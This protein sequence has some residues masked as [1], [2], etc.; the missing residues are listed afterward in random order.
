MNQPT[1][2]QVHRFIDQS[3]PWTPENNKNW[4]FKTHRSVVF[5]FTQKN[6]KIYE[7]DKK[8]LHFLPTHGFWESLWQMWATPG[9]KAARTCC[10]H[11]LG[12]WSRTCPWQFP[13]WDGKRPHQADGRT[14]VLSNAISML[15][16]DWLN[17]NKSHL[18]THWYYILRY[19]IYIYTCNW[20]VIR[21]HHFPTS[22]WTGERAQL[23][24]PGSVTMP[25]APLLVKH[26]NNMKITI[27]LHNR[28]HIKSFLSLVSGGWLNHHIFN[29]IVG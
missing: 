26:E 19:S 2:Q 13:K 1:N 28:G 21:F 9:V 27:P 24:S 14:Y 6:M 29:F 16:L 8:M 22:K 7:H 23:G 15:G 5:L 11:H 3:R 20:H 18:V 25:L 17:T 10:C 4:L 12:W